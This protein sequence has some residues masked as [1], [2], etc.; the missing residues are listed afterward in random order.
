MSVR[1]CARI[2][3]FGSEKL[4]GTRFHWVPI[5]M[6][7]Y[8]TIA[9]VRGLLSRS[10]ARYLGA[11]D[12][13]SGSAT[14]TGLH[15]QDRSAGALSPQHR[16]V[17]PPSEGDGARDLVKELSRERLNRQKK[18]HF[19]TAKHT[20]ASDEKVQLANEYHRKSGFS[21]ERFVCRTQGNL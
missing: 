3:C 15:E 1:T 2:G 14:R 12:T 5:G 16:H 9:F 6:I 19:A 4:A 20:D 13:G 8:V 17:A 18:A 10:V 21:G 11:D 7:R